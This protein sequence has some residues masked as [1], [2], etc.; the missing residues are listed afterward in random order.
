MFRPAPPAADLR[1]N[2]GPARLPPHIR[3]DKGIRHLKNRIPPIPFQPIRY[4]VP[5]TFVA[6]TCRLVVDTDNSILFAPYVAGRDLKKL[7]TSLMDECV[8]DARYSGGGVISIPFGG[9][10]V[11]ESN[12]DI[13]VTVQ[14]TDPD[15]AMDVATGGN[16]TLSDVSVAT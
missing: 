8:K 12:V 6:G 16:M 15:F 3:S 10:T 4:K 2:R 7:S 14:S 5:S 11:W 9:R 13:V 1:L